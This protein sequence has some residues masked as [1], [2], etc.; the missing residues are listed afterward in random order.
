MPHTKQSALFSFSG[1]HWCN[2]QATHTKTQPR[3]QWRLR[4]GRQKQQQQQQ[5]Q[6]LAELLPAK[7]LTVRARLVTTS[8]LIGLHFRSRC[9]FAYFN[10]SSKTSLEEREQRGRTKQILFPEAIP[11]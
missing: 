2:K 3:G 10:F 7:I 4:L 1:N 6:K 9:T 11:G 5:L 8:I